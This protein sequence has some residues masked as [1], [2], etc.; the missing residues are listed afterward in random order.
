MGVLL[1]G[2]TRSLT[3]GEGMAAGDTVRR[4]LAQQRYAF[5]ALDMHRPDSLMSRLDGLALLEIEFG[6]PVLDYLTIEAPRKIAK[7]A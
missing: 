7:P 6:K 1:Q 2:N 4:L 5:F 3:G